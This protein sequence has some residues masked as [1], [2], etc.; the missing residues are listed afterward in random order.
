MCELR[1]FQYISDS[2]GLIEVTNYAAATTATATL[3]GSVNRF[4]SSTAVMRGDRG[5]AVTQEAFTYFVVSGGGSTV[6]PLATRTT[7]PNTTTSGAQTTTY[8]YSFTPGTTQIVSQRTTLPTVTTAQNGPGTAVVVDQVF[9]AVGREIWSRDGDGFLRYTEYDAQT[10]AVVKSIVDV[11]TSR[12]ADFQ[13]LP[14]GWLTPTGGGLHLVTTHEVDRLGR[15]TKATD[16]N[17]NVTFTVYDDVNHATRTYVGWNTATL[18][19]TGPIQ[20]SRRDLSGTYTESLT[21]S[22]VPA[23]DAQGR[24]TG[25]EPI[26]NLE[27]LSR[28]LV[29]AAGQVIAVDR[30][31]NLDGLAYSTATA[32]LGLE[33]ENYL[34]TP[35][36]YNNQGQ[37]DRIQNPAGTITISM[38]DGL[39]R[40][41]AT[42]VG[43]DDSTTNGFKWTPSNASATSKMTQVAANEYDNGGV[44]NGNL[45]K[46]TLFP[47]GSDAPRITENAYDWRNRLVA[48][49]TGGTGSLTT[50]DPSVNRPLT[51]TD[52]DN[53]GR[54]TGRS[55]YDGDGIWVIDANADGVPDKPAA[56]LLRSSQV[57]FYD[58][59]DRVFRTQELF[60]NQTT[61]ALGAS[62]LTTNLF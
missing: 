3:A 6:M 59:Q 12:T 4:V 35:Y 43:T 32:T 38:Y 46:S 55:V 29:N 1:P 57:S 11:D 15:I 22:A 23:V 8:A 37:V 18:T 36:A 13:N 20:V 56:A 5:T 19:P 44:G 61:G 48:T 45:T 26:T 51:F 14:T 39:A 42:Y 10:G 21:Y 53:L 54:V 17:G 49:K 7:Y 60:V 52:Y 34:R 28:S 30:Y 41:T 2:S 31:T 50:E 62:R 25:T 47:G 24:P 33:G 58:A 9:D 40:L 27:S 16:P